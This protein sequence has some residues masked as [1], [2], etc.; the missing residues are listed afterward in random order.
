MKQQFLTNTDETGRF[1]VYSCRTG[2]SYYI[3]P[4]D[5]GSRIKWGDVDPATKDTIGTYGKKYTG[6][7]KPKDSLITEENGFKNIEIL[8][9]GVSPL[10]EINRIDDIRYEEGYRPK[11][12][13]VSS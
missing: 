7:I 5:V 6:A 4:L 2:I 9:S 12:T 13:E 8:K 1:I 10:G 3:E 11:S